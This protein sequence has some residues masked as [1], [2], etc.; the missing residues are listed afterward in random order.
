MTILDAD[1]LIADAQ[2][3]TGLT[4]FGDDTLPARVALVVDTLN[5]AAY[6]DSLKSKGVPVKTIVVAGGGHDPTQTARLDSMAT[7]LNGMGFLTGIKPGRAPRAI[8]QAALLGAGLKL[9]ALGRVT[10]RP[11]GQP[12][13]AL[14]LPARRD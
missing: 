7:W 4:D 3:S 6:R 2:G 8:P 5:S 9:D 10:D 14:P 11:T 1:V 12:L 13:N